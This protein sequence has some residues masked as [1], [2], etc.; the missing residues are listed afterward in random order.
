MAAKVTNEGL[1]AALGAG[2][3]KKSGVGRNAIEQPHVDFVEVGG[4]DSV[5]G[6]KRGFLGTGN[7]RVREF[8][9]GNGERLVIINKVIDISEAI[10]QD[11]SMGAVTVVLHRH[12][13]GPVA[14]IVEGLLCV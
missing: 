13:L 7:F 9:V 4:R 2:R 10:Q 12:D 6:G 3:S 11:V 1:L 8:L 5:T 14:G